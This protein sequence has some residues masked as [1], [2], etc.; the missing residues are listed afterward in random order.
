MLEPTYLRVDAT[1]KPDGTIVP[2]AIY[3]TDGTPFLIDRILDMRPGVSLKHGH[4]G[5]RYKVRIRDHERSLYLT[6]NKWF[7]EERDPA[8]K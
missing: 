5:M 7:I 8:Q 4:A 3:W 2:T 6:D 1:F